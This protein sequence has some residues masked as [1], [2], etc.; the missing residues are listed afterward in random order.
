MPKRYV[1]VIALCLLLCTCVR[2]QNNLTGR[3]LDMVT[4]EP[5]PFATVYLDGTS[6]G[7]TTNDEGAF[8]LKG[9]RLPATLVVSHLSYETKYLELTKP[10]P[11]GDL[12]LS[13]RD[14]VIS[15]VEVTEKNLREETLAEFTRL[16]LGTDEWAEGATILNDEV[17]VFDRD[18]TYK[19]VRVRSELIRKRLL[20]KNRSDAKWSLDGSEYSYPNPDNLKAKS[21]GIMKVSLPHLGYTLRMDLNSFV[22]DYETRYTSYLGTFYFQEDN[23]ITSRHIRNRNR[24]YYGS[25][26]HFARALMAGKLEEN[27]FQ[28]YSV[29]RNQAN[30]QEV[31]AEADLSKFLIKGKDGISYLVGLKD[32]EFAIL[33]YADSR[34]RPLPRAKWKRAQPVQ[35]RMIVQANKCA[36]L[37]GGIFGD[38]HLIFTGNIGARSLAWALPADFVLQAD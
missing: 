36:L 5:V 13:P 20:K 1:N 14:A 31:I 3:I 22:S 25:G 26:M 2:A 8:V 7:E 28:A 10:G 33:Y 9:V 24:A 19:T 6:I 12:L 27:G 18:Y 34:S 17:L 32:R 37:D 11:L 15:G 38:T 16:L 4:K 30:G 35:S 21:Q 23:P 29:S